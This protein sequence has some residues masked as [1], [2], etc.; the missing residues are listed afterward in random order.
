[1]FIFVF[2]ERTCGFVLF[3]VLVEARL[4]VQPRQASVL[5]CVVLAGTRKGLVSPKS[6][7]V[8]SL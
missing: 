5:A 8:N 6:S 1:M 4:E 3:R 2:E 7:I